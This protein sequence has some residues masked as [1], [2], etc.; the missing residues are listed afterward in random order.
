[1]QQAG[2]VTSGCQALALAASVLLG[3]VVRRAAVL[4]QSPDAAVPPAMVKRDE[5][6]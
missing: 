3:L 5:L 2:P 1:M 6:G 4:P